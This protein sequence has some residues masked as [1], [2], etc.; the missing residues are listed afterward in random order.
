MGILLQTQGGQ[1]YCLGPGGG[2]GAVGVGEGA[3]GDLW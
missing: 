3:S 2:R 1:A